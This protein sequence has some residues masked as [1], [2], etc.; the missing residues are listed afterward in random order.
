[1]AG[2]HSS[3]GLSPKEG[4]RESEEEGVPGPAQVAVCKGARAS[5]SILEGSTEAWGLCPWWHATHFYCT[6]H[7]VRFRHIL[8]IRELYGKFKRVTKE[9]RPTLIVIFFTEK[10]KSAQQLSLRMALKNVRRCSTP[11]LS[12]VAEDTRSEGTSRRAARARGRSRQCLARC[13]RCQLQ[14]SHSNAKTKL[15]GEDRRISH[16]KVCIIIIIILHFLTDP[17]SRLGASA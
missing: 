5:R 8:N 1:M 11:Y 17:I 2:T 14:N 7:K 6:T 16:L 12:K 15:R 9:M 3:F 10:A 4:A 13:P